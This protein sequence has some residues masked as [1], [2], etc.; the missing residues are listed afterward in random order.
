MEMPN[1][2]KLFFVVWFI[3]AGT[4][5]ARAQFQ[6]SIRGWLIGLAIGSLAAAICVVVVRAVQM[7]L[8]PKR[9]QKS[10]IVAWIAIC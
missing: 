6:L 3:C 4:L 2:F 1:Q 10:E 8:Q 9:F 5:W 7:L